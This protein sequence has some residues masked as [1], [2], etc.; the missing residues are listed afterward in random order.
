MAGGAAGSA[1]RLLVGRAAEHVFGAS[2]P[3]GTLIVNIVGGAAMGLLAGMLARSAATE[4]ARLFIGMGVLGG[5]TTFSAFSLET[6]LL[7]ERGAL[8]PALGYAL[9]SVVGAIGALY[10]G[11]M[12]ARSAL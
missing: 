11:L 12:L 10:V 9:L 1:G 6:V 3:W 7:I 8:L 4:G 5:F 2:F